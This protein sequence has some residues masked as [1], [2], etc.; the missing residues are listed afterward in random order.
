MSLSNADRLEVSGIVSAILQDVLIGH[1]GGVPNEV[2]SVEDVQFAIEEVEE[3][4]ER[5][6]SNVI[7]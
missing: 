5:S 3:K 4:L 7:E 1:K 6:G 2:V